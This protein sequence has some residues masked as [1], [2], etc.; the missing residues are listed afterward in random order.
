MPYISLN[1]D[2]RKSCN[3]CAA[4]ILRVITNNG[5]ATIV[6]AEP[7]RN[8]TLILTA[9]PDGLH[10]SFVLVAD[11]PRYINEPYSALYK[12]HFATCPD[13]NQWRK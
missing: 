2:D 10:A 3:S 6:D 13:A 12:S 4:P 5:K 11:R 8:G 7:T 1:T 9:K